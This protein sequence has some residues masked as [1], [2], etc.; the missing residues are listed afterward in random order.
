MSG[1]FD[2]LTMRRRV[3]KPPDPG[4]VRVFLDLWPE[5]TSI[6]DL[7][8]G[9]GR[10]VRVLRELGHNAFGIDGSPGIEQLTEGLVQTLDLSVKGAIREPMADWAIC[11]EVGEH[12]PREC[13]EAFIA[14]VAASA[15]CGLLCSWATPGQRGRGHINCRTPEW[16]ASR[17]GALLLFD[18]DQTLRSRALAGRGWD[19][20]LLLF[21]P[22]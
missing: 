10:H 22:A 18:E 9:E 20:K 2:E 19:R 3:G 1:A 6:V 7:G 11:I 13:E 4:L 16:V 12:V 14:N 15:R 17:F 8:A 21:I 5:P